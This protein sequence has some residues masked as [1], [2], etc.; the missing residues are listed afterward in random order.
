MVHVFK[1]VL[2]ASA[3]RN[4]AKRPEIQTDVYLMCN[5][6]ICEGGLITSVLLGRPPEWNKLI[7]SQTSLF[8]R[9]AQLRAPTKLH[10]T[11]KLLR[12]SLALRFNR[13]TLNNAHS[14]FSYSIIFQFEFD[15]SETRTRPRRIKAKS[16]LTETFLLSH[17][18]NKLFFKPFLGREDSSP[19]D[20]SLRWRAS[21]LPLSCL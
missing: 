4:S 17:G 8:P 2:S 16:S 9:A 15:L 10:Y 14:D 11:G 6:I 18:V 3:A 5:G 1:S 20:R 7:V 21:G 19:N 13:S 12:G